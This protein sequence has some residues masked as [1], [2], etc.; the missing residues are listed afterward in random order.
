MKTLILYL[1]RVLDAVG[2]VLE[3]AQRD[4]TA[5]SRFARPVGL[6]EVRNH[7][8]GVT[9]APQS[10]PLQHRLLVLHAASVEIDP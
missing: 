4:S 3:S 1:Q 7:H 5:G 10:S 6:C 9:F 2:E 8:Q